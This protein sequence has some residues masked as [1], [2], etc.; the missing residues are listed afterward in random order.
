MVPLF[1]MTTIGALV[2]IAWITR[3]L[4]KP[5]RMAMVGIAT[6]LF[7]LGLSLGLEIGR[8]EAPREAP[9]VP[10]TGP[11]RS[12]EG[13]KSDVF[14]DIVRV[15]HVEDAVLPLTDRERAALR[16]ADLTRVAM[17]FGVLLAA[18]RRMPAAYVEQSAAVLAEMLDQD[19]DGR[20]DDPALVELLA[21]RETA[22][23][24]M[25]VDRDDWEREQ[26]PGLEGV[27]GY[28]IVIPAWWLRPV[29]EGPDARGRA[30]MVE[31]IHHFITQF[32]LSRLHPEV[33]GVEDWSSVIAREAARARCDFWQHPENDCPGRPAESPGD[34]GDPDCDVVEFFHQVVVL[35]A[36]MRPGWFGIGFPETTADLEARLGDEIKAAIDDPAHHQLRRPLGFDYPVTTES[37][38]R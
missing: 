33:F 19:V 13:G 2:G 12:D 14:P 15:R 6:A 22:W 35:R 32:G 9:P 29:A 10:G 5:R 25:P 20:A 34:C 16:A 4:P 26:L 31:E 37:T 28:D 8:T 3:P 11:R 18:D 38:R 23:L 36:G 17:P 1:A 30:V 7:F 21:D 27:L 24:A